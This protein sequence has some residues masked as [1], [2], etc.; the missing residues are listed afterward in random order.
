MKSFIIKLYLSLLTLTGLN[1][2][3][4]VH[5]IPHDHM[6]LD[7]GYSFDEYYELNI[8]STFNYILDYLTLENNR[9]FVITEIIFFIKWY[10]TELTSDSKIK[11][12]TLINLNRIEFVLG[13]YI[14]SEHFMSNYQDIL[15][16][17]RHVM[18]L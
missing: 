7:L 13:G 4:K 2:I 15:E 17:I 16:K 9:T 5:I 10:N 8:F 6:P 3:F 14:L 1:S 11:F 12:K 18:Q